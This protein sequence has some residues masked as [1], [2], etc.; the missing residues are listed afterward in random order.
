M[1]TTT[2]TREGSKRKNCSSA[3]SAAPGCDT[4]HHRTV[5]DQSTRYAYPMR[6]LCM[7]ILWQ[8]TC[9][10]PG[11]GVKN[12]NAHG[13]EPPDAHTTEIRGARRSVCA[14][15]ET[16]SGPNQATRAVEAWIAKKG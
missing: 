2:H 11:V 5:P 9:S 3:A 6:R 4:H 10:Q 13:E 1:P 12:D 15:G 7:R 14:S 16:L 8:N